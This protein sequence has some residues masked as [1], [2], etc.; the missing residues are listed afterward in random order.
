VAT[1]SVT[2]GRV[3]YLSFLS[4]FQVPLISFASKNLQVC[5]NCYFSLSHSFSICDVRGRGYFVELAVNLV[6]PTPHKPV[7]YRAFH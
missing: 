6:E 1:S 2:N 4:V 5:N 7:D 3:G